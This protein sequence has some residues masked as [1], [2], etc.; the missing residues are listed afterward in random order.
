[1]FGSQVLEVTIGLVLVYLAFSVACSGIKEV[2]AAFL[3]LRSKTL[4]TAVRNML[5]EANGEVAQKVLEHPMIAGTTEPGRKLP[6]YISSR[7][8]AL[9]FLDTVAAPAD[10]AAKAHSIDDLRA[11]IANLPGS[12][13]R[14]TLLGFV[15]SAQGDV[16]AAQRKIEYWFDDTMQ[17]VSGWYKRTAQKII[18]VA[19][20]ALCLLLNVD[21]F[22]IA[23]ELW[24]DELLRNA[25]VVQASKG[26]HDTKLI[27]AVSASSGAAPAGDLTLAELQ[28]VS[29]AVT[30]AHPLPFGWRHETNG[31]R[32]FLTWP[33]GLWKLL[34]ILVTSFAI[35]MG[36]P[37]W[38]DLL[39][40]V[41]N[42]RTSGEPPAQSS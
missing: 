21:T 33:D 23:R 32:V 38:F 1:V 41:I 22:R 9:A 36:A 34:G 5:R 18:F 3:D 16:N 27:N 12:K 15:D 8:F 31:L 35:L 37:F 42:L 29:T 28:Q 40:K 6:S 4:E 30:A 2:I 20:I 25:M 10:G 24:T 26:V 39:N 11:G 14:K 13:L 19:G 17:R 7:N